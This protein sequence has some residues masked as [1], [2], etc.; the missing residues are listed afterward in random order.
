MS[1]LIQESSTERLDHSLT[2]R[3]NAETAVISAW[4]LMI[5]WKGIH[6]GKPSGSEAL[7]WLRVVSF[8]RT[9]NSVTVGGLVCCTSPDGSACSG[10]KEFIGAARNALLMVLARAVRLESG[11]ESIC[12][13]IEVGSVRLA[14]C[15]PPSL[16][17]SFHHLRGAQSLRFVVFSRT[18]VS[19]VNTIPKATKTSR[20]TTSKDCLTIVN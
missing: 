13:K 3:T 2:S 10:E 19:A 5:C 4:T 12:F 7:A 18:Y 6:A 1:S 15:I 16:W 11:P 14:N 17:T 9:Q 8:F 20:V